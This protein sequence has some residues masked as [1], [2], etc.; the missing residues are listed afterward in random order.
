MAKGISPTA[1]SLKWLR[2]KGFTAQVVERYNPFAYKRIDLFGCID[3][4]AI[5]PELQGVTGVQSTT[6]A[7]LADHIKKSVA[8]PELKL[9]LIAGNS[10]MIQV[11]R[12]NA[13]KR[14]VSKERIILLEDLIDTP[15]MKEGDK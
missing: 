15:K 11:W 8:I 6:S 9:W 12:K 2:D 13:K 1:R 7:H 5:H 4:V 14:W 3:I 10:F